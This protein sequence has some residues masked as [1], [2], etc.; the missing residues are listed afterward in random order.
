M[1]RLGKIFKVSTPGWQRYRF[2]KVLE[3]LK[4]FTS[5]FGVH[6]MECRCVEVGH[7]KVREGEIEYTFSDSDCWEVSEKEAINYKP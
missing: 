6:Y 5:N 2:I 7:N 4:E 3:V 1:E